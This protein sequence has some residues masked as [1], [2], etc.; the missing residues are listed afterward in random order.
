MARSSHKLEDSIK[1]ALSRI[2]TPEA[3]KFQLTDSNVSADMLQ[4]LESKG[5]KIL[6]TLGIKFYVVSVDANPDAEADR[7]V[8][9]MAEQTLNVRVKQHG[10]DES[11]KLTSRNM[12]DAI[13]AQVAAGKLDMEA[14]ITKLRQTNRNEGYNSLDDMERV[15]A[16]V[17]KLQT[18]NVIS[19]DEAGQRISEFLR[20][21]PALSNTSTTFSGGTAPK[22]EAK[23]AEPDTTV[24]DLL[25][26]GDE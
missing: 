21:L 17:R 22:L 23:P 12:E 3:K 2:V 14:A 8:R 15:I 19:D 6:E 4:A 25:G 9:E 10:L 18:D 7:F 20:G 11:T 26:E 24:G 1:T 5:E 13:M 16:F